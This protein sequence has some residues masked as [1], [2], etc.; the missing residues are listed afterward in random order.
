MIR[1]ISV[2]SAFLLASLSASPAEFKM[3]DFSK[4]KKVTVCATGDRDELVRIC[5]A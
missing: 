2:L 5:E 1:H 4:I 3:P